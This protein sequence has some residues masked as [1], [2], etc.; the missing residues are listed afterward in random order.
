MTKTTTAKE[1]DERV[2]NIDKRM[3]DTEETLIKLMVKVDELTVKVDEGKTCGIRRLSSAVRRL[4][5]VNVLYNLIMWA[6]V[7]YACYS[8]F[9]SL[10]NIFRGNGTIIPATE[11]L[12]TEPQAKLTFSAIDIITNEINNQTIKDTDTATE[13][14]RAELPLNIQVPVVNDVKKNSDGTIEQYPAAMENTKRRIM[15]RK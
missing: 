15:I 14:L 7:L 6:L 1:L 9:P 12:M 11:L 3:S 5:T 10:P 4:F 8:L 13:A 2:S